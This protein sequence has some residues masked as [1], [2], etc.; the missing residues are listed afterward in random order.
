M[1]AP[2]IIASGAKNAMFTL[3]EL[4]EFTTQEEQISFYQYVCNLSTNK[5]VALEKARMITGCN[6]EIPFVVDEL[7]EIIRNTAEEREA[8][9]AER[10]AAEEADVA[11]RIK[12]K[13]E[14]QLALVSE[15]KMPFG[16]DSG[17]AIADVSLS[18]INWFYRNAKLEENADDL[19]LQALAAYIEENLADDILPEPTAGYVGE[20]KKRMDFDVVC[21]RVGGYPVYDY[22]GNQSYMMVTTFVDSAGHCLVVKSQTFGADVGE[23][24]KIKATV[25]EHSLYNGVEQT[26]VQRVKVL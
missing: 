22:R 18:K 14:A 10:I 24:L 13:I 26:V 23:R 20:P 6:G 8:A 9:N 11:A 12:A 1:K 2:F 5:D 15:G 25:K 21:V 7:N 4:V 16:T 17:I 3:R 19:V